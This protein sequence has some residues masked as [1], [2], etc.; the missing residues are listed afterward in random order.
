MTKSVVQKKILILASFSLLTLGLFGSP[1]TALADC[2]VC[3]HPEVNGQFCITFPGDYDCNL[4]KN[5]SDPK[6]KAATCS[7]QVTCSAASGGASGTCV[8]TPATLSAFDFA[9]LPKKAGAAPPAATPPAP[10]AG[11]DIT[12][13]IPLPG[14]TLDKSYEDA[15]VVYTPFMAQYIVGFQKLLI[16]I[17][18]VVAAIMIIYGG[19]LYIIS[20]TGAKV[21]DAKTLIQDALI[22][23]GIVLGAYLILANINP[24]TSVLAPLAIPTIRPDPFELIQGYEPGEGGSDKDITCNECPEVSPAS[25]KGSASRMRAVCGKSGTLANAKAVLEVWIKEGIPNGSGYIRGG[26]GFG[27]DLKQARPYTGY[28]FCKLGTNGWITPEIKNACGLLEDFDFVKTQHCKGE[29]LNLNTADFRNNALIKEAATNKGPCYEAIVEAYSQFFVCPMKCNDLFASHCSNSIGAYLQCAGI[30]RSAAA[31]Y[32]L[33]KQAQAEAAYANA[34]EPAQPPWICKDGK[35]KHYSASDPKCMAP[36]SAG[37][38]ECVCTEYTD[39]FAI[40]SLSKAAFL[41][42]T[43]NMPFGTTIERG[44]KNNSIAHHF[45]YV[46]GS[47]LSYEVFEGGGAS[48]TGAVGGKAVFNNWKGK[49]TFVLDGGLRANPSLADYINKITCDVS[50]F[51]AVTGFTPIK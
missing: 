32:L 34:R 37:T 16:G 41:S 36:G 24:N 29:S 7:K 11:T 33:Q 20:S 9:S 19:L 22:G 14:V 30:K 23:L 42:K 50:Y 12:L 35:G 38:G 8:N 25:A 48:A 47:G 49:S 1:D 18:I 46:K 43:A 15:G 51:Y 17:A 3:T 10:G 2:C 27:K 5:V 31:V 45:L 39:S 21:R 26:E 13:N 6:I 40:I 44:C 4:L 28:A